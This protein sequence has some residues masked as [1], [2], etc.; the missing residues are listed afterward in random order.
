MGIKAIV[1]A[2]LIIGC[3]CILSG[4]S[5]SSPITPDNKSGFEPFGSYSANGPD[6]VNLYNGNLVVTIPLLEI[7]GRAGQKFTIQASYNLKQWWL[8]PIGVNELA[9]WPMEEYEERSPGG[10]R[11]GWIIR[12]VPD[13]PQADMEVQVGLR[14]GQEWYRRIWNITMP[15][16]S[17]HRA[18][19]TTT[20][21]Y[22]PSL[23]GQAN[24]YRTV[25]GSYLFLDHSTLFLYDR[26]GTQMDIWAKK[27]TD[28]NGN[29]VTRQTTDVN[30]VWQDTTYVDTVSH[31]I[32]VRHYKGDRDYPLQVF[33]NEQLALTFGYQQ[34]HVYVKDLNLNVAPIIHG[35][36]YVLTSI[37]L[38]NQTSYRF[39]YD[40][41][42]EGPYDR[43][44]GQ[45]YSTVA[46]KQITYPTGGYSR[47]EVGPD[48][49]CNMA[50][51]RK[52]V[53]SGPEH[54]EQQ[55]LYNYGYIASN[56]PMFTTTVTRP[57]GTSEFHRFD[58]DGYELLTQTIEQG[59][60]LMTSEKGYTFE[61]NSGE[62]ANLSPERE[63]HNM[64]VAY[65]RT[66][67]P[68]GLQSQTN[69]GY[70]LLDI[71]QGT[72]PHTTGNLV[73][74]LELGYG[75]GVPG[76]LFRA[77][78]WGYLHGADAAYGTLGRHI[79][80]RPAYE[81]IRDGGG[82]LKSW[83]EYKYD[84][85]DH[86][87]NRTPQAFNHDDANFG[88]TMLLRGNRVKTIRK[89]LEDASE[90]NEIENWYD[91]LGNVVKSQDA[92]RQP[93][94]YSYGDNFSD[95]VNRNTD[96]YLTGVTPPPAQAGADSERTVRT[97]YWQNGLL[98]SEKDARDQSSSYVYD[99]MKRVTRVTRPDGGVTRTDYSDAAR[100][101]DIYV[102][103]DGTREMH[104]QYLYD[105]LGRLVKT[106]Q[107][108][109]P[110]VISIVDQ[111]YDPVGRIWKVSNPYAG[112][113]PA[114][115]WTEKRYDALNRM[116]V[117]VHQDSSQSLTEYL[118]EKI[119][120][121]DPAGK[122]RVTEQDAAGRLI[123][124]WEDPDSQSYLTSY[125]YDVFDNLVLVEQGGQSRVFNYDSL[126]RL[127]SETNP[128]SGD[129]AGNG[130]TSYKY[131]ANGLVKEKKDP[132]NV[133]TRFGYD[134]LNRL[135][136]RSYDPVPGG[137]STPAI[138]YAYGLAKSEGLRFGRLNTITSGTGSSTT[139]TH[140]Y[141]FQ[142]DAMGR[143]TQQSVKFSTLPDLA[144]ATGY[145]YDRAGNV[146]AVQYPSGRIVSGYRDGS[147]RLTELSSSYASPGSYVR[148]MQYWPQ[149]ALGSATFG[150]NLTFSSTYNA[151]LQA[152]SLTVSGMMQL[153]YAYGLGG[154]NN[155][156]VLTVTDTVKNYEY[157][158][159]YDSM[160]RIQTASGSGH[161]AMQT[162]TYD[163]WGNM[164]RAGEGQISEKFQQTKNR[165]KGVGI[166][167][168]LAGNLQTDGHSYV[169]DAE[170]RIVLVDGDASRYEYDGNGRRV[171]RKTP[172]GV[173]YYIYGLSGEVLSEFTVD[174][175]LVVSGLAAPPLDVATDYM[176]ADHLGT[177]RVVTNQN[178]GEVT[179]HDY[180]PFGEEILRGYPPD[181]ESHKFTSKERDWETNLDFFGARYF[182]STSGRFT[183]IDPLSVP[184]LQRAD[185]D[186]FSAFVVQPQNWN[187]YAYARNNPVVRIDPD[188]LYTF[189][190]PGTDWD[191][192]DWNESN[193]LY[194]EVARTFGEKP[195]ILDWSG[196]NS[197]EAR[198][199]AARKLAAM[200]AAHSF[201][202][203]E[204]L[205]I[206]AH[207]HGGNIAI[208]ASWL[209]N[210]SFTTF[211]TFGTPI[212][213]DY[214]PSPMLGNW[215]NV[216]SKYDAIQVNG[217]Y[218]G[219]FCFGFGQCGPA[220]R[221]HPLAINIDSKIN[222]G[223]FDTHSDLWRDR[224][225]WRWMVEPRLNQ[226]ARK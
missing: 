80:D 30:T 177:P 154:S 193:P 197:N 85:Q 24:T 131:E 44:N 68:N 78:S 144:F 185:R 10:D 125:G 14:N 92:R 70:D 52:Y 168:D 190:L 203:G 99:D 138:T 195:V 46:L 4:Q 6:V 207:S 28:T 21:M 170:N 194:Q 167:Y 224:T 133:I 71:Q 192:K 8:K 57:D 110:N 206:I 174:T 34:L 200:I 38:P 65:E 117:V 111:E 172:T 129:D 127:V 217:G 62:G 151:R 112:S 135:V 121:T 150:N 130:T 51:S 163:L 19:N 81:Q 199:E 215:L 149:G 142:Y 105:R 88:Q 26:S 226:A 181:G 97:Y 72:V 96:A 11:M 115:F 175:N 77:T 189:L 107:F 83:T 55:Y 89:R 20:D 76:G 56:P 119:R 187:A 42:V 98:Q 43:H 37:T 198:T 102:S 186:K 109:G 159:G 36:Y 118:S 17:R 145:I 67:L 74:K 188:G 18:H 66:T 162:F 86:L 204:S 221:T 223:P 33:V 5:L 134:A 166:I 139:Q 126:S 184:K 147:G 120:T 182:S 173:T 69:Y 16:G 176:H 205:N 101:M 94:L 53:W 23:A 211:V 180:Y 113:G 202:P 61:A 27:T 45:H 169:Y 2:G 219:S 164:L 146:T 214:K 128:E 143:I 225:I 82:T 7:P 160:N 15:D 29:Y 137:V 218:N 108:D 104:A 54:P 40:D 157:R 73:A 171:K 91:I 31:A 153:E 209:V 196:G 158:Y 103:T 48:G 79:L 93:T 41:Y 191:K 84:M 32:R 47:Y 124:V 178:G 12:A 63:L 123:K 58:Q 201:A 141:E 152:Q 106:T 122:K 100:T 64:R 1:T 208:E 22:N 161:P 216:Y 25:D 136:S 60:A 165:R 155:G 132:R 13:V 90:I 210:R 50:V 212:R 183:S 35:D 75:Q 39:T 3:Q 114:A 87:D 9:V 222:T 179:R 156:N 220:N 59:S 49:D 148:S 213:D 95:G 140:A 116:K